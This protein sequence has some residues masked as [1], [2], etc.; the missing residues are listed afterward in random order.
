MQSEL[1]HWIEDSSRFGTFITNN[2]DKVHKKLNTS[3]DEEHRMD[4]RAEL[5]VAYLIMADRQFEIS[6]EAYG[7]RRL[8]P[9]LTR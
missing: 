5:L 7:A 8:G 3:D 2:Q 4:V 6:F 1:A 9:D